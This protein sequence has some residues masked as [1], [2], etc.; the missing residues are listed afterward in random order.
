MTWSQ[1]LQN[2]WRSFAGRFRIDALGLDFHDL[3]VV[4]MLIFTF[5]ILVKDSSFPIFNFAA[6]CPTELRKEKPSVSKMA[7][8][9]SGGSSVPLTPGSTLQSLSSQGSQKV[10]T[11]E[12]QEKLLSLPFLG[13][14]L[15]ASWELDRGTPCDTP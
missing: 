4:R 1:S 5:F 12:Q 15:A 9:L 13:L 7:S 10:V 6:H 3:A 14:G 11:R 8:S 2:R